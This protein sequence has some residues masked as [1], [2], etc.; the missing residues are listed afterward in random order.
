VALRSS[1]WPQGRVGPVVL[2]DREL[3]VLL[4]GL[5]LG[6]RCSEE[7]EARVELLGCFRYYSGAY[8]GILMPKW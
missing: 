1:N 3:L 6:V 4:A 5:L 8:F 7:V 2:C